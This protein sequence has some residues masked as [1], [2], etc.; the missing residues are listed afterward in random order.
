MAYIG[1]EPKSFHTNKY[2][3]PFELIFFHIIRICIKCHKG[4]YYPHLL[5]NYLFNYLIFPSLTNSTFIGS[6]PFSYT[7]KECYIIN[8]LSIRLTFFY[9][10]PTWSF[11]LILSMWKSFFLKFGF[12]T[13]LILHASS[14]SFSWMSIL[15][16]WLLQHAHSTFVISLFYKIEILFFK[17]SSSSINFS[18]LF[19]KSLKSYFNCLWSISNFFLHEI[20][21][22]MHYTIHQN[23]HYC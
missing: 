19:C 13:F 6:V 9:P 8:I 10:Y 17:I 15:S 16:I 5:N 1:L 12:S 14:S 20:I 22:K 2:F 23:H 4:S 7:I 11:I 3:Q 18:N 21:V